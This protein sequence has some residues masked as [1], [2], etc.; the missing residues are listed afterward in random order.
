MIDIRQVTKT[1]GTET[2]ALNGVDIHIEK[3]EFVSIVGQSG[4]GKSTLV[5]LLIAEEKPTSGQI[6][7]N[8][9][10]ISLIK[11]RLIP[12]YR[13]H[14]GVVFQDFRLLQQ[15]T[16]FENVSFALEVS[17]AKDSDIHETVTQILDMV[18][19]GDKRE[20]FP[21]QLSGGEQQRV[22][23]ARALVH[24]PEILIA[25]EPTGNLDAINAWEI[26]QLLMKINEYGATVLLA[27]HDKDIVNSI[28]KRV[29]TLDNGQIV[30]EQEKE[31]RYII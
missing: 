11:D 18:N 27:T 6:V 13:R 14:I 23:I 12:T 10:D 17:G 28:K 2:A 20:R 29:I 19:L 7:V 15:K 5:R 9:W 1:Y 16:V 25:D 26:V 22:A 8:N 24:R 3:G 30:R 31:G 4:T 21:N